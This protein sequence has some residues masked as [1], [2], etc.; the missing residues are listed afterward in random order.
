[1]KKILQHMI[2]GLGF[3]SA[4]YLIIL[5][6]NAAAYHL[7]GVY[8]PLEDMLAVLTMSVLIGLLSLIF[9][10]DRLTFLTEFIIHLL[11]TSVL[12]WV[13]GQLTNCFHTNMNNPLLW[14]YFLLSYAI[15][16]G[17]I[18][19]NQEKQ[20]AAINAALKKRHQDLKN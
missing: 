16:W 20:V 6:M 3:G 8:L 1:M 13:T 14:F 2:A 12:F 10:S 4:S 5:M 15:I 17:I 18:R 9:D 11:G 19:L 7:D